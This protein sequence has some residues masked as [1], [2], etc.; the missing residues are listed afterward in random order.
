[1]PLVFGLFFLENT[2][3]SCAE[4]WSSVVLLLRRYLY[5]RLDCTLS[6]LILLFLG[7]FALNK[8]IYLSNIFNFIFLS[9]SC[10]S[11][12]Q[13]LFLMNSFTLALDAVTGKDF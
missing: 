7:D 3:F 10:V 2:S 5:Q 6:N 9:T 12:R 8:E 4:V 13:A 11:N 1:M